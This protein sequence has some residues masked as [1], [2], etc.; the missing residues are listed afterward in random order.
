MD[1]ELLRRLYEHFSREIYLYLYSMC[2]DS[3]LSEDLM[4]ECFL[5]AIL[6]LPD[7]HTN[8]RA[9]LCRAARNLLT[10]HYR[11]RRE[12]LPLETAEVL[13]DR[14]RGPAAAFLYSERHRR[15]MELIGRL[16]PRRREVLS[17]QYY[18]GFSQ[19]EIA[20]LLHMSH[21][22]VRVLSLRARR[23]LKKLMEEDGYD[24]S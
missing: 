23:E 7:E 8:M 24:F 10:D 3:Q 17:L 11:T 18:G 12:T 14:D 2:R 19:K 16:E 20:A 6:S 21:E 22:N 4:Q 15:L 5:R 1:R 13:P 9:W